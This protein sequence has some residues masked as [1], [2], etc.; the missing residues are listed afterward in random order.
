MSDLDSG[1]RRKRS[2]NDLKWEKER[3][4]MLNTYYNLVKLPQD[5]DWYEMAFIYYYPDAVEKFPILKIIPRC[6]DDVIYY[7]RRRKELIIV[8][9]GVDFY[10]KVRRFKDAVSRA[11]LDEVNNSDS[12]PFRFMLKDEDII[13]KNDCPKRDTCIIV[14]YY[15]DKFR[16]VNDINI[17]WWMNEDKI[18]KVDNSK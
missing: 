13:I 6:N 4:D 2:K 11:L 17:C 18:E 14:K 3:D 15:N 10:F 8:F 9:G 5:Y 12:C 1:F 16:C 7:R